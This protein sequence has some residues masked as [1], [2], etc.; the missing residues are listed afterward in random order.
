MRRSAAKLRRGPVE[1]GAG[2]LF[3]EMPADSSKNRQA[4]GPDGRLF[5]GYAPAPRSS[6]ITARRFWDQ[7]EMSLH[8][9][10]GRSLP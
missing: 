10:T 1:P 8:T 9:A 4:D 2:S 3:A 6:T 7:H 5:E